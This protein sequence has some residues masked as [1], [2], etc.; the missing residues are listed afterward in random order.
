MRKTLENII[1]ELTNYEVDVEYCADGFFYDVDGAIKYTL[2]DSFYQ[3]VDWRQFLAERFGFKLTAYNW[4][5]MSIL[6]ELG[7][8]Y[9]IEYFNDVEWNE[10]CAILDSEDSHEI[11]FHH[12]NQQNELIAT[13]WAIAYYNSNKAEMNH[14]NRKFKKA[15]KKIKR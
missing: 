7:H 13:E 2:N 6:H 11:N 8:H 15:F 12:F 3:D 9:T 14:I 1:K 5:T 4:F 10:M